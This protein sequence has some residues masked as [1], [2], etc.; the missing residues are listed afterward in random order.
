MAKKEKKEKKKKNKKPSYFKQVIKEMQLVVFP[1]KK[2]VIK[3]TGATIF[4]VAL[5]IGFF[6]L[7]NLALSLVKGMF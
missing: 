6:E 2:E 1:N 7:L 4:I 5:M 3:Y